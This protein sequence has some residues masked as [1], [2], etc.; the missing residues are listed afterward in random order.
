MNND[1]LSNE[2]FQEIKSKLTDNEFIK[3]YGTSV[4]VNM[5]RE[6]EKHLQEKY[7]KLKAEFDKINK[8]P[9]DGI[10]KEELLDFL[11]NYSKG[12]AKIEFS[13]DYLERLFM[14]LDLDHNNQITM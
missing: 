9:D 6:Y 3:K 8:N 11:N 10:D 1:G 4:S 13:K 5:G 2:I 7:T 14:F 12:N